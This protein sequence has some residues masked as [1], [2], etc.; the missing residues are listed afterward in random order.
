M[1]D[2]NKQEEERHDIIHDFIMNKDNDSGI[3]TDQHYKDARE[4]LVYITKFYDT[5]SKLRT[6]ASSYIRMNQIF[7]KEDQVKTMKKIIFTNSEYITGLSNIKQFY[8]KFI[9]EDRDEYSVVRLIFEIYNYKKINISYPQIQN[10]KNLLEFYLSG[11]I[12]TMSN[13]DKNEIEYF[14][15]LKQLSLLGKK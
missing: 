2:N 8:N 3:S 4:F 10:I 12:K 14:N 11:D 7:N 6:E 9:Q 13:G 5:F 1:A 15:Y